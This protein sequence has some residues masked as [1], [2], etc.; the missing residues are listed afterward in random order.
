MKKVLKNVLGTCLHLQRLE[1]GPRNSRHLLYLADYLLHFRLLKSEKWKGKKWK[2][3]S[4]KIGSD[5][6]TAVT[7]ILPH[8]WTEAALTASQSLRHQA[9]VE[10]LP[11]DNT[12]PVSPNSFVSPVSVLASHCLTDNTQWW[13]IMRLYLCYYWQT[14]VCENF[15]KSLYWWRHYTDVI[16]MTQ[17]RIDRPIYH[18]MLTSTYH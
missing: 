6:S 1:V 4:D 13:E 16:I 15:I 10:V 2:K 9:L 8:T 12:R 7:S 17:A 11:A 3:T 14:F 18:I 5:P